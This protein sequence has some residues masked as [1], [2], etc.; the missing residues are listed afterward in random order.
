MPR[1]S[2]FALLLLLALSACRSRTADLGMSDS[3]FVQVMGEL[4]AVADANNLTPA[5]RAQRRDAV[6]RKRGVTAAQ[7]E[8]LTP[9]LTAHP[10]HARRLWA[11]IDVKA[12]RLT[13]GVVIPK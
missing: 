8:K 3:A 6:L 11:A 12:I 7:L 9:E 10:Q 1:A 13:G 4:K 5:L 2:R